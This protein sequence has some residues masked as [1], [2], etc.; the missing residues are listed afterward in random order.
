MCRAKCTGRSLA[1]AIALSIALVSLSQSD[2]RAQTP[3]A[4][5]APPQTSSSA[6]QASSSAGGYSD[7]FLG[8]LRWRS[9][10]P[11]RGGRS[12]A[13]EGS[14]ARPLEYYFGTT[15]GG[16]WK[17]TNGGT[18]WTPVAD[19]ALKTSSVGAVAIAPSNPDIVYV[20]MG[21]SQ[22]RGNII[23]GDGV[24]KTVDAGK[25]WT[26]LGLDKTMTVARV[27]V[28]P[29]NP[30]VVYVAA[31]GHPYASG[32]DRGV[33]RS[34][35]GGKSWDRVLFRDDKTGAVDLVLDPK[36]PEVVYAAL[37]EVFRTPHSLSSGGPGSGLFKSSDAGATWTELT[38]KAGLPKGVV[39]RI[40]VSVS[41]A[42]SSCVYAIVEAADGGVFVSNDAGETW[43]L[44]SSD[45]RLRQRAFY[46]TRIN[47]DSKEKDTV[48][49]LNVGFHRSTDGGKT[50]R[51]VRVPH[52]DN[53][54]LWIAPNDSKR[55]IEA[56]DG[57]ANV[58]IDGGATWTE[59][60][61]PTA[62]F[63]N[64]F[65][66]NHVPYH[67][68][69]AQQDNST[70]CVPSSGGGPLYPVGGGESGYIAPHPTKL[71][72]FFAGSYGGLLTRFN[73]A[74]GQSKAVNVWPENPMGHSAKDIRERF[75]WTF[76]IMIS[77]IEPNVLYVSSQHLW[78]SRDEGQS[79]ERLSGDLTRA[80]PSTLGPSG[81]PITLDQTG[82][83][84]YA[85][86]FTVAPSRHDANVIWTGSDDGVVHVTRDGGKNWSKVTP[87]D[88]PPFTRI[89][90]IEVSPHQ[91]ATAYLAGNRYQ[92]GDRSPYIYKTDDYG[93]H[94]TKIVTGI[95]GNDFPRVIREDIE[96]PGLLFVGTEHGI[97]ASFNDGAS[98]QSL[99]LDLP[100]TPVHGIVVK[101]DDLVIGT[102]GRSFYV[103]D[104]IH[105]LRQL[106]P[107]VTTATL[108]LF[109]PAAATRRVE[110]T[111][112]IDYY[113]KSAAEKVRIQILDA[114]GRELRAFESVPEKKDVKTATS[115]SAS[116]GPE[117]AG[118]EGGEE[119][120]S[121][122]RG[123]PPPRVTT[124]AGMNRVQWDMRHAGARDFPG[125]ILWAGNI[126]G[127]IALPGPYQ[128]KVTA[129]GETRTQPLAIVKDP[130]ASDVSEADLQ[131]QFTLA[132]QIRDRVTEANEA[133]LRIRH[134]KTQAKDRAEAAKHAKLTTAVETFSN[135]L[136]AIEG[137]IYQYRNQ[138]N[139][140]PLNYPIKLNNK[141]AALQGIV[142]SADGRP[143]AQAYEV[144]KELSSRLAAQIARLEAT[145]KSELAP[146]NKLV[147][148]RK[149]APIKDEVPPPG[150]PSPAPPSTRDR[151]W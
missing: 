148:A 55:M 107:E 144:F 61:Y 117:A 130:R 18:T 76:P 49:V 57:G 66:T 136:T 39:G 128:V 70:A 35:D 118:G 126:R 121:A 146:L 101:D 120:E 67:V 150:P 86:I 46:Y 113:L 43:T 37:W 13:V 42:D 23:Q 83:E 119:E 33:Y 98:W 54:D 22:L 131:A 145:V 11:A 141:I 137:Q 47:A 17:T 16:L 79:W 21:E 50:Y 96:R 75:Q 84:T 12:T 9:I 20:G 10:G 28:H 90:M 104:G 44:V 102:H 36:N 108:H 8:G 78:R 135:S 110:Q 112:P 63:Y 105:V 52:G 91:P 72:V 26:H 103:L 80:D 95:P 140:D 114:T 109:A 38:R 115:A 64:V 147:A 99:R 87:P 122:R 24:Y 65:V 97:Y 25:T 134:L 142:E 106:Q 100:V 127:P 77:P 41:G 34:R 123:P 71:D 29:T 74:T 92:K 45:R 58:S 40:G 59:Q 3:P 27:R 93:A 138:S 111:V 62:Q 19:K 30:D 149:L 53:H 1:V 116:G 2:P 82:V 7:T 85:T 48:Y 60:D 51:T 89:S 125:M 4:Q 69:G 68:C 129:N 151:L 143:T 81:G 88:L 14:V 56:N 124:K 139:Q 132:M 94:W 73:R 6:A 32:P 15:G 133:V 31:L 5:T